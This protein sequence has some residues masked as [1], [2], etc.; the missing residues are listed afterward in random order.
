MVNL[1]CIFP[2]ALAKGYKEPKSTHG[3]R[4]CACEVRSQHLRKRQPPLQRSLRT[5]IHSAA[6]QL[7]QWRKE[8]RNLSSLLRSLSLLMLSA[9]PG[10]SWTRRMTSATSA[11]QKIPSEK[12]KKKRKATKLLSLKGTVWRFLKCAECGQIWVKVVVVFCEKQRNRSCKTFFFTW[13]FHTLRN[14]STRRR[15]FESHFW[16]H[17]VFCI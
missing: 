8:E 1:R 6:R 5:R 10:C 7:T 16:H 4:P 14:C 3:V 2:V 11:L 13:T 12:K 9:V 17:V 15:W